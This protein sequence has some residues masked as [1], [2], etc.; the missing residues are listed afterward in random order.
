MPA[1]NRLMARVA[2]IT[3]WGAHYRVALDCG[4]NS[5]VAS[6]DRPS[7]QELRLGV[8]D[9][10]IASFKATAVHVIRPK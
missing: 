8:G 3:R 5:L 9:Q 2:Q 6:L 4:A 7:F 1:Q 10:I